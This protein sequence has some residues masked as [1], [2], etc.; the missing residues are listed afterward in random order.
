MSSPMLIA[1]P[2]VA[3]FGLGLLYFGGL[4]YT[5]LRLPSTKRPAW[6]TAGSF[7]L[8]TTLAA[9]AFLWFMDPGLL[10]PLIM[11]GG[12]VAARY[13][14]TRLLGPRARPAPGGPPCS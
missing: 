12:F 5:L 11:L 8:R 3:G 9:A 7:L 14:L 2:L 10:P 13:L 6:L 4:W 1:V